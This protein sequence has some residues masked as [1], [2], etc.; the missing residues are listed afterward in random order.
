MLKEHVMKVQAEAY[1]IFPFPCIRI[2]GFLKPNISRSVGYSQLLQLGKE[3]PG[4]VFLDIGCAFGN[5]VRSAIADG[6]PMENIIASDLRPDFWRLGLE[7]F[8]SKPETFTVP[9]LPGDVLDSAFI[10]LRDPSYSSPETPR[11]NL[12]SLT[13]LTPLLSHVSAIHAGL[14][15]HVFDEEKQL[16]LARTLAGLLSSEPG[17]CI[18]GFHVGRPEKGF[19]YVGLD[20]PGGDRAFCH[21]PESWTQLWDGEIFNRGS[22]RVRASLEVIDTDAENMGMKILEGDHLYGMAWSV[23]RI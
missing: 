17:S 1:K 7:L 20:I 12:H 8:M 22:V 19:M 23:T 15:F 21:S 13:S 5:D 6:F 9:F 10:K 11:P 3:R 16:Q 14:L 4:A 18:F 2:F